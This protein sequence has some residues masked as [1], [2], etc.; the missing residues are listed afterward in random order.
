M[1]RTLTITIIVIAVAAIIAATLMIK[2]VPDGSEAVHVS[3]SG[4]L[5]VY[6]GGYH[7]ILPGGKNFV[8]YPTGDVTF[9]FPQYGAAE[10]LTES[11]APVEVAIEVVLHIPPGSSLKLYERF[12]TDF[13]S[14]IQRLI[15]ASAEI[16]AAR[17][18]A[19]VK[20]QEILEAI[21]PGIRDELAVP[22]VSIASVNMPVWGDDRLDPVNQIAGVS[23]Q[24]PRKLIIIGVDGGDWINLQPLIDEGKLTNF[25]RL[26]NDGTTGPLTTIEPMLSPLLWTTIA[27]GKDPVD[28]G[29][30]N[31]TIVDPASGTKVPITRYHRKV[32]AFW[33]MLGDYGRTVGIVGWLA[34][35]P[36]E[37]VNG[38]IVTDKAGYL[39][40]APEDRDEQSP[41]SVS[42]ESRMEVL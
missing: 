10:V 3:A 38:T 5:K 7:L 21:V 13:E 12:S 16:E 9:R 25:A 15:K 36:A 31:F 23:P 34:T 40:F 20:K 29:I 4:E 19:T 6:P 22:G 17:M 32:D 2:R 33:N 28:H 11:G 24:P 39:A 27:T 30:L 37:K 26:V 35:H 1:K 8:V 18:P 14:A 41:G 42:P